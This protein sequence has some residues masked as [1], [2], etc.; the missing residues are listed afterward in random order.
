MA[1]PRDPF[2]VLLLSR[3]LLVPLY[4]TSEDWFLIYHCVTI[5]EFKA[6]D[7]MAVVSSVREDWVVTM[8]MGKGEG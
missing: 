6:Y 8:W 4:P 7:T 2:W 1:G 3:I 5:P